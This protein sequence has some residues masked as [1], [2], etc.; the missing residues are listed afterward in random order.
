ML[1]INNL[2]RKDTQSLVRLNQFPHN[3]TFLNRKLS[4]RVYSGRKITAS[5][6]NVTVRGEKR[7]KEQG[8]SAIVNSLS[9]HV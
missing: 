4:K 5:L 3:Q 1:V 2:F 8:G 6:G 7:C 9:E